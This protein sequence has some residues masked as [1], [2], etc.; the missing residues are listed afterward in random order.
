GG[1]QRVGVDGHRQL[2]FGGE[3]EEVA[4][5]LPGVGG[6]AA[7]LP[8]LEQVLFVVERRDVGQ[9]DARD[10]QGAAA[11]QRGHGGQHQVPDRG[12]QDRGVQRLGRHAVR[13]ADGGR[14][15]LAGELLGLLAAGEH[16]HGGAAGQRHLGGQVCAAAEAVDAQ[17][18]VVGK[19]G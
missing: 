16:V 14:A 10:R 19:F 7:Q 12:E 9:V 2:V 17:A 15:E 5:V 11:V 4:G 3:G 6:D 1:V 13:V 8:L 18:A